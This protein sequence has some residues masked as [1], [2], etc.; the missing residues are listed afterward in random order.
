MNLRGVLLGRARALRNSLIGRRRARAA[1]RPRA[2]LYSLAL[3]VVAAWIAYSGFAALFAAL[4]RL[5]ATPAE[6]RAMLA[7]A[8]DLALAGLLLFD[9]ESVVSTLILD[10]DL[11][12]LRRA[13]LPPRAILGIKLLD[14]LPRTAAPLFVVALPA[15]LAFAG[16]RLVPGAAW[17]V[18]PL[19]LALLWAIPLGAGIALTLALL[20]RVP[21]RRVRESL[22]LVSTLA[23]TGLW[24]LNLFVLPRIASEAGEPLERV[25]ALVSA[26]AGALALTPGGWAATLFGGG[27]P[28]DLARAALAL[29]AAAAASVA[30][31]AFAGGRHLAIVLAAART[32]VARTGARRGRPPRTAARRVPLVVAVMRRDRLLFVRDWTVLGDVLSGALLWTLV[33]L[34]SLPLRPFQSPALVRAMLLTLSVGMGYEIAARAFPLERRGAEWM[35]L[36]PVPARSWAVARLVS[37]G[38]LALALVAIAGASLGWAAGLGPGDWLATLA[39][40]LPALA[41]S[42]AIGLW[43]GAVFGDPNW[44]SPRAVLTLGGRLVSAA[45]VVAQVAGWLTVTALAESSPGPAGWL[46]GWL[47][48]VVAAGLCALATG[49]VARRLDTG[50]RH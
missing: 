15:L 35:R 3:V 23:F 30:L 39:V 17:L 8:L 20:S 43:T 41:L 4:A 21:A 1:L 50:Y 22:G 44:T 36:T 11:D 24:L 45:L 9:L 5:G 28:G 12:L 49:A 6:L 34:L 46:F 25:R 13:P 14:A 27:A 26:A 19:A 40:V 16:A 18:A 7:L 37:A 48:G 29:T 32:P 10:R 42:I 31:A 33:P 2:P 47:P 38:S